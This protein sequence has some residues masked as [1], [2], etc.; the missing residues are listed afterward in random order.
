VRNLERELSTLIRKASQDDLGE[1]VD[2]DSADNSGLSRV[3]KSATAR[4][5]QGTCRTFQS[6]VAGTGRRGELLTSEAA[7]MPGKGRMT[8]H[9]TL[10][11]RVKESISAPAGVLRA[12]RLARGRIRNRADLVGQRDIH[13]PRAEGATPK[14][15]PRRPSPWFTPLSR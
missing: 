6:R 13:V 11:D 15:G 14:D 7:M 8:W 5:R 1:E 9:G 4:S 10:R 12:L 2:E 3:P